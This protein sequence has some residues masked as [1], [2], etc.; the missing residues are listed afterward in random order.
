M[1]I[2]KLLKQTLATA[3]LLALTATIG[4]THA[5]AQD[6]LLAVDSRLNRVMTL[7]PFSGAV[8][9]PNFIVDSGPTGAFDFQ[10]PRAAIQVNQEIWVSDQGSNSNSIFRFGLDGSFVGA[11]GGN[12]PAGGLSNIRGLRFIDGTVYA[13]NAGTANGAPGAAI[14]RISPEGNILGSFST[15]VAGAGIGASPWDIVS[16]G[17]QFLVSDGTSRA[18]HLFNTDGSYANAFTAAFNNLPQQM[19]VRSNGHVLAA[20]N[21]SQPQNSFGLYEFN[22]TGTGVA[23]WAGSPGLGVRGVYELGNGQYLI[24][25]AGGSNPARGLGTIDPNGLPDSTNFTLVQGS[26]N[27]GWISP[28]NLTPIPEPSTW[29]LMAGGLAGLMFVRRVSGLQQARRASRQ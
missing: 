28:A 3:A 13:V 24:N 2:Y 20:A 15:V 26:V 16:Y 8:I 29:L 27:G 22:S 19:F 11:I 21:G 5:Q 9:N 1:N 25:E 17:G 7:D 12:T 4:A 10:T 18:L 14:V 6:V 23:S